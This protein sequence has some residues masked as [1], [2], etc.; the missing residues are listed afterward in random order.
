MAVLL[1]GDEQVIAHSRQRLYRT[2]TVAKALHLQTN[3][4]TPRN[5][6]H[7]VH[8]TRYVTA[9]R[10]QNIQPKRA[11]KAHLHKH[12]QRRQQDGENDFNKVHVHSPH[13]TAGPYP[14]HD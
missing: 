5:D 1:R 3:G 8:D 13:S 2:A 6:V 10:Q 7:R 4:L 14:L 9:Q 11:A 12:T